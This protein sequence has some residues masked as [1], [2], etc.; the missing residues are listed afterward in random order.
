MRRGEQTVLEE[1][2]E[3]LPNKTAHDSPRLLLTHINLFD[4][5]G[6]GIRMLLTMDDPS[7]TKVNL[8]GNW[9]SRSSRS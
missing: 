7:N 3:H 5:E 2:K 9:D 4:I 6:I 8:R 1:E